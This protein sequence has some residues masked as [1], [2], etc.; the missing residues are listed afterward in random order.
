MDWLFTKEEGIY[1]VRVA[2]VLVR[3]GRM[4]VQNDGE[5]YALPG[6]HL[7]FGETMEEALIR[8]FREEMG[9]GVVCERLL[10]SEENFWRWGEKNAHNLGFYYLVRLGEGSQAPAAG[11]VMEDNSRVR[12]DWLPADQLEEVQIYPQFIK[13]EIACLDG[14]IK[15]FVSREWE[16]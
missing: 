8:E 5:A 3:E 12:F 10:W 2:G 16:E 15:H 6:G 1:H 13:E 7:R 11:A 9:I 14:P 4:L